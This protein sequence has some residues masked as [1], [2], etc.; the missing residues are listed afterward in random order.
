MKLF[1]AIIVIGILAA[2]FASASEKPVFTKRKWSVFKVEDHVATGKAA[3]YAT[4]NE[5]NEN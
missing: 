3:C 4:T 5:I 1:N 2:S